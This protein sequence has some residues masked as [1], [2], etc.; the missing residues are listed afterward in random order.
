MTNHARFTPSHLAA[1]R[2]LAPRRH[3]RVRPSSPR[4]QP[5]GTLLNARAEDLMSSPAAI[6]VD[7]RS[8]AGQQQISDKTIHRDG[9]ATLWANRQAKD[10]RPRAT[11][12]GAAIRHGWTMR[13]VAAGRVRC[14]RPQ[15]AITTVA[16]IMRD[17]AT[18]AVPVIN[19]RGSVVGVVTA[20]DILDVLAGYDPTRQQR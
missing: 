6:T 1:I 17:D 20:T 12:P 2:D 16:A 8:H 7:P 4:A 19:G 13:D 10:E 15:D 18:D 14:A 5:I 9:A 3:T 11:H